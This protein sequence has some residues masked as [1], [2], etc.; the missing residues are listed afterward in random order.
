VLGS[1][2]ESL[3]KFFAQQLSGLGD[4]LGP[5]LWQFA[6]T[7]KFEADDFEAFLKLLPEEENGIRFRH[8]LEA[9]HDSFLDPAF[10]KL[11]ASYGAA[12]VFADHLTYPAIADVTADF[13]Y[14]RLQRGEDSVP[15][16][17]PDDQ[18]DQWAKRA[19]AWAEGG[20]PDD[21][22]LA[23]PERKP[24]KKPRDVFVYFIH[25]GK[26][27]APHAARW[28]SETRRSRRLSPIRPSAPAPP[29]FPKRD[30]PPPSGPAALPASPCSH[31]AAQAASKAGMPCASR[32]AI[33][34]ARTSPEPAV[35]R[36][37]VALELIAARPSGAAIDRVRPLVK[38]DRIGPAGRLGRLVEFRQRPIGGQIRKQSRELALMWRQHQR[39]SAPFAAS[40]SAA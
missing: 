36:A 25:E 28:I 11:A 19:I 6:P 30:L 1:A 4:K 38:H 20:M 15:T 26:V 3:K 8:A 14:A 33:T 31:A 34:P 22:P 5:I 9:R 18:M 37:G 39:G 7:K 17:Y 29:Q 27:R 12:I 23:A 10:V 35:A 40:N 21:L 32:P 16:A 24:E 13:V 2:E